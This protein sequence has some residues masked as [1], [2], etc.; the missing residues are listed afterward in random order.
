MN[1]IHR[2]QL[3][4]HSGGLALAATPLAAVASKPADGFPS[5]PIRI[6]VPYQAGGSTDAVS[7][8]LAQHLP[9]ELG[10]ATVLVENKPGAS[11]II[12]TGDVV[13]SAPDGH[14][15]SLGLTS[16]LLVN[17]FL[18]TKM[19]YDPAKDLAMLYRVT[20]AGAILA[21][22]ADMPVKTLAELRQ[23]IE[24]NRNKLSYGSYGQGS[25]PHLAAER[26]NQIT[27]G[28]MA[29]AAYKGETPMVQALLTKEIDIGWGSVQSLKQHVDLGK[30]RPLAI[31]GQGRVAAM[32]DVP[33]FAEAGMRDDAF[34]ILAWF[35]M[36]V[37]AKT[38]DAIQQKLSNAIAK[39]LSKPEVQQRISGM[40]YTAI[41]TS[42]PQQFAGLYKRDLP[43]WEALVKSVGVQLD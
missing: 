14:T 21:V 32:K 18:Y 40:G 37:P 30:L 33:T 38:P 11:G 39:V 8:L 6:V 28:G 13:K 4:A 5:K 15:I 41:T 19:P 35:G 31:T 22:N 36:A 2:R 3:L 43:K 27:K 24:A 1:R 7:R 20:D 16:S 10:G 25:Y 26:I 17:R 29:H 34:S 9:A 12:G 42:T 23:Y